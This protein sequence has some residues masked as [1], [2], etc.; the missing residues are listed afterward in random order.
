MQQMY[1]TVPNSSGTPGPRGTAEAQRPTP[2]HSGLEGGTA[3]HCAGSRHEGSGFVLFCDRFS[4][5]SGF[6]FYS[7]IR[8][9]KF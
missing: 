5:F 6:W 8:G 9:F 7:V 3:T 2:R 4:S 1:G